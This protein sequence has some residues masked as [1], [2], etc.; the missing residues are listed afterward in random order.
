MTIAD[1]RPALRAFLLADPAIKDLV[2]ERIFPTLLPQ[3]QPTPAIVIRS[4]SGEGDYHMQGP[5][6][7]VRPRLQVDGWG[8][9]PDKA[10]AVSNAVHARLDGYAGP[11]TF[12][13][14]TIDVQ[15]AFCRNELEDYDGES[16]LYRK[17]R[18]Y[19]IAY[20]ER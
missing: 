5:S 14:E 17:A 8:R 13:A 7:L 4:I 19:Q 1:I 20:G 3:G 15:G 10:A 6:G 18:D 12:G 2:G 11:M 16:K 9:D